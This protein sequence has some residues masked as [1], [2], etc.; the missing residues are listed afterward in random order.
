MAVSRAAFSMGLI[1]ETCGVRD[2][3]LKLLPPLTISEEGLQAGLGILA[4]A[5]HE[6][7]ARPAGMAKAHA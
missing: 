5:V 3:V 1:I 7:R 4:E 6:V 2:Q